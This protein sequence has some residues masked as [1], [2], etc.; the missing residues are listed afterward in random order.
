[1]IKDATKRKRY[2]EE[3]FGKFTD[4]IERINVSDSLLH[5]LEY[6]VWPTILWSILK[7]P[8][9]DLLQYKRYVP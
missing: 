9:Q 3:R 2:Q 5:E 4:E 1:M 7:G 8:D 6:I